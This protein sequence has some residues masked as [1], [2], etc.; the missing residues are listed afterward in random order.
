MASKRKLPRA[1]VAE[2]RQKAALRRAR[3]DNRVREAVLL[4]MLGF[5]PGDHLEPVD[6]FPP[7]RADAQSMSQLVEKA[8][9]RR[10]ELRMAQL[11]ESMLEHRVASARSGLRPS[12]HVAG[13][14]GHG[15]STGE[16]WKE[17]WQLELSVSVPAFD[18]LAV[19]GR[20]R[21]AQ[22]RLEEAQWR[23]RALAE[24]VRL[25][26]RTALLELETAAEL[27]EVLEQNVVSARRY[28]D[29]ELERE[30]IGGNTYLDVL[31]ARQS[32]AQAE[33]GYYRALR[34]AA[35]ARVRLDW[36]CGTIGEGAP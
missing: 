25:E 2:Q 13:S 32:L 30:K 6:E 36:A 33:R 29:Y 21:E 17:D 22:A 10:P 18:G 1:E 5:D 15:G 11:E 27:A 34:D 9:Q 31:N 35:V 28:L 4:Q 19:R 20:L 7:V 16:D 12:V 23:T 8:A 3:N 26:I 24:T 14:Y